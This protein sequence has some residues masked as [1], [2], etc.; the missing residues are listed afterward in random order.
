MTRGKLSERQ[1][2][3]YEAYRQNGG[4]ATRAAEAAGYKDA[5][6]AGSRL[7][8][9]AHIAAKIVQHRALLAK[10]NDLSLDDALEELRIIGFARMDHYADLLSSD[11]PV[12]VLRRLGDKAAAI[13]QLTVESVD[14]PPAK[15]NGPRR[16]GQYFGRHKGHP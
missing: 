12:E 13:S 15:E 14:L 4:N 1:L 5:A 10:R 7:L 9:N 8:R 6:H 3:F 11:N 16:V 2:R